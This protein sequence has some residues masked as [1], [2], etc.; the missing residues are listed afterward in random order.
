MQPNHPKERRRQ[1]TSPIL[2]SRVVAKGLSLQ[3]LAQ[4][5]LRRPLGSL[6]T[7]R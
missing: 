1:D 4:A 2:G 5:E 3:Q 7:V 6:G